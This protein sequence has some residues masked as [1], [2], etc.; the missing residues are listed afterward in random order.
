[1]KSNTALLMS[2]F[3]YGCGQY[4]GSTEYVNNKSDIDIEYLTTKRCLL[5]YQTINLSEWNLWTAEP[6]L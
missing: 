2:R 3:I 4:A 6:D 5:N 1:M